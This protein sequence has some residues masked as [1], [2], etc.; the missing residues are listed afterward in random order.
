MFRRKGKLLASTERILFFFIALLL[1]PSP[2]EI[3]FDLPLVFVSYVSCFA[4]SFSP[5]QRQCA[6]W[7]PLEQNRPET[8]RSQIPTSDNH[9]H[10]GRIVLRLAPG[11]TA[12]GPEA[13]SG[14]SAR[15]CSQS[16]T[17]PDGTEG[18]FNFIFFISSSLIY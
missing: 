6:V 7:P 9:V 18:C 14:R 8:C 11:S 15:S 12:S 1:Y 5:G 3:R 4:R 17:Q 13:K 2:S 16:S 10:T